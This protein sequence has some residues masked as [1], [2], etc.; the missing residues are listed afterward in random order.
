M[1]ENSVLIQFWSLRQTGCH[2]MNGMSSTHRVVWPSQ[3]TLS[4]YTRVC[5]LYIDTVLQY[6]IN[7]DTEEVC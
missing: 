2:A 4:L 3:N 5:M 6:K 7:A 1:V